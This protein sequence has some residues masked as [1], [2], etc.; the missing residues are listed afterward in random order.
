MRPSGTDRQSLRR[1][2]HGQDCR[3]EDRL[4]ESPTR[5]RLACTSLRNRE[6]Q[7]ALWRC[8]SACPLCF[9]AVLLSLPAFGA[10]RP[11]FVCALAS[12]TA[13]LWR[14]C[15]ANDGTH[16]GAPSW[17]RGAPSR[18]DHGGRLRGSQ[19]SRGVLARPLQAHGQPGLRSPAVQPAGA[20]RPGV[21]SPGDINSAGGCRPAPLAAVRFPAS[22]HLRSP[23]VL[24]SPQQPG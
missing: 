17:S 23:A 20:V 8:C 22:P 14:C 12:C 2:L 9:V 21:E 11:A 15:C 18:R 6:T 10:S 19:D 16:R 1:A 24:L 3:D 7:A 5:A 4:R 13:A